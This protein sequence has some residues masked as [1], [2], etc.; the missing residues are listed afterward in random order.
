MTDG[1]AR[2]LVDE[3]TPAHLLPLFPAHNNLLRPGRYRKED[4][5]TYTIGAERG[6]DGKWYFLTDEEWLKD[7]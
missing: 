7:D 1:G 6:D 4:G 5:R 3:D 2:R